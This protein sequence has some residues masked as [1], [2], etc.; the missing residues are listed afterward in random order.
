MNGQSG[1][2]VDGSRNMVRT[3]LDRPHLRAARTAYQRYYRAGTHRTASAAAY[4]GILTMLPFLG[5]F[6]LLLAQ[7]A[8]TDPNFLRSS[9]RALQASLGLSPGVVANLYSAQGTASLRSVLTLLGVVGLVYAGVNWMDAV[10]QGVW[11][12]WPRAGAANWW[13]RYLRRWAT[14]L[15][16]LPGLLLIVLVA[17][18]VGRSPYRL[19]IDDGLHF[20]R[21]TVL[22]GEVAALIATVVLAGLLCYAAYR[23][24][25]TAPPDPRVRLAALLAGVAVGGLAAIGAFALPLALSNPYGIVVAIL[26]VMLWVSASVRA[27]LAMAVWATTGEG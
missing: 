23:R 25:G 20:G 10:E 6:Y 26:A 12:V 1:H 15:V 7:L 18:F 19:L 14:L 24:V 17:V 22:L 13:R 11:S 9:R 4:Y 27:M 3:V 16:T 8:H 21:L 5:L 2:A